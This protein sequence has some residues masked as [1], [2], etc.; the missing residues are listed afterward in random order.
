MDNVSI[1]TLTKQEAIN[2]SE[3]ILKII[4]EN[5]DEHWGENELFYELPMKFEKSLIAYI[6]DTLIGFIIASQKSAGL[7]HVHKINITSKIQGQGF[8]GKLLNDFLITNSD[9]NIS[10]KVHQNNLSA[11]KFYEK[12][13]FECVDAEK[14]YYSFIYKNKGG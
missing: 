1:K 4:H 7:L 10:L 14:D 8:G 5:Y 6:N 13:N 3:K 9:F 2:N 11:I 12:L